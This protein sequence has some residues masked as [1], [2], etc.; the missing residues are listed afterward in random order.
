MT[1]DLLKTYFPPMSLLFAKYKQLV[2]IRLLA[3]IDFCPIN[4]QV[5]FT[6]RV[7]LYKHGYAANAVKTINE[8]CSVV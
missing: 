3:V 7:R 6:I 4:S 8:N 5:S 1:S 2:V